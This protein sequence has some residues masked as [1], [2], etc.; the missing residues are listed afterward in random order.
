MVNSAP[1]VDVL[2][3]KVPASRSRVTLVL[4]LAALGS[5]V[6]VGAVENWLQFKY[7][8]RNSGNVPQRTLAAPQAA[9]LARPLAAPLARPLGLVR[10]VA[11]SDAVFTAPV[12]ADGRVY[13]VDGSGVAFCV[14]TGS[15]RTIWKTPTRGGKANCNNVSSPAIVGPYLHFGTTAGRYYVLGLEDGRVV[16]EIPCGGPI[17]TAPVAANGRAYFA[18]VGARIFAVEKDGTIAWTWDFVKE[19]IGFTGDRWSGE[20]WRRHKEGRVT[21]RD[22]FCSSRNLSMFGKTLV[23]PAGGRTVFLED[24]GSRPELRAVG[25]IPSFAGSEYPAAFGQ[26]IGEDGA[27]YVQWHRRDNAGR[28]EVLRLRDDKVEASFVPGT[29]TAIN[30]PGLL[31]FSSVSL[32]GKNVYRC[33]PEEGYGFVRH[34]SENE[35]ETRPLGG[36]PSIASPILAGEQGVYGALDGRLYVVPLSGGAGGWSF[37]TA[38]GKAISAPVAVADGRIYFGC[39]DGYLYVLGPGGK[40]SLPTDDLDLEDIRSP[41]SGAFAGSEYDWFTNYGNLA[42]TNANDQG[43]KPPLKMKWIRRYKGTFKHLPVCGGGRMYTHTSEGQIFAVEQET[44]RLLWRRY[45]PGVF[46]SF[47]APIYSGGRLLVPQAGMK[48]SRLRCL[49]AA[50]GKLIWEAPFTGSPSWSR[51]SAPMIYGNLAIYSSGSGRYAAQGTEKPFTMKGTPEPSPDGA[52]IMSFI[53]THDN[54][55]YPRDNKPLIWAWNVDTGELAWK[56]DLSRFGSGGNDSG[57]CLM[58]GKLYYSTFFGYSSSKRKRRGLPDGPNGLTAAMEPETGKF[59]WT[60]T[61]HFVTAGCTI[62]GKDGR[63]YLGGYNQA[64]EGT[65]DRHVWCLDARDGSLIWESEPVRSSVNVVAV[66]EKFIFS[67]ASGKDGHVFDKATG[68]ILS[69]FNKGYACTRFTF[70]EPFVM[71]ANMDMIDVSKE[72]ELVSTGP[73]VDSRECVGSTVSNGRLFYTSQASG[74]QVSLVAGEEARRLRSPWDAE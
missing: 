45:F 59:L 34:R 41:L 64:H 67:N 30:L 36:Y 1:S 15:F 71:G 69:R 16:K 63:L 31:S 44:G 8:A 2:A 62:S 65:N 24:A 12:V 55:Y 54:P 17:F 28:V 70:S 51:Q 43:I 49:D 18:T 35:E 20:D 53:Y 66:G 21:W 10:A 19:V 60:T 74:L 56:K 33:R 73:C 3:T 11:L 5:G 26:S 4:L 42:S 29:Q 52:E 57:V 6:R 40:A 39:E 48:S 37:D 46:L 14:D 22:H 61:D 47:T 32:R 27:V 72:G 58:D 25:F 50:T 13:V 23:I 9:P 7:D 68:K 38:F